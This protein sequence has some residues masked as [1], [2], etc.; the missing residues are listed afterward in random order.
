MKDW[1]VLRD[2]VEC[3]VFINVPVL[4][5]HG[6]TGLTLSM[7]NLMGICSGTRGMMHMGIG[8]KVSDLT[9]FIKP[10]LT[11]I[12]ATRV[13]M[14]NGPSG[15]NLEDVS[16]LNKIIAGVDPVLCDS[17]A[18][19]MVNRDPESISYIKTAVERGIGSSDIGSAKILKLAV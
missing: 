8:R 10:E 4:K 2:A 15:G 17:Y 9:D 13:L 18:A 7:K 6:L 14:R 5:H 19:S 11:V 16:A 12:D 1:P 3:D